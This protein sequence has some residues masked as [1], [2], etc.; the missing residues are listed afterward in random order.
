MPPENQDPTHPILMISEDVLNFLEAID[1][2]P[3]S[4]ISLVGHH[5]VTLIRDY[6]N[7][8][9]TEQI[10]EHCNLCYYMS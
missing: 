7:Q 9:Q 4:E 6:Y 1:V 5:F 10:I 2:E 3:T 8:Y